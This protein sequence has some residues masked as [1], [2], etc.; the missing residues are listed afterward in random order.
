VSTPLA[1][2][3]VALRDAFP[4]LEELVRVDVADDGALGLTARG[5]GLTRWFVHDERGLVE[6]FPALDRKLPLSAWLAARRGWRVLSFR[7]G[8]RM[9]VLDSSEKHV[10]V[11]K[12]HKRGRAERAAAHQRLAEA[13]TRRGAFRVPRLVRVDL[14]HEALVFEHLSVG[15]CALDRGALGA[16]ARLGGELAAFQELTA[17]DGLETFGVREEL[18]VLERWATRAR[19]A[20]GALPT[21][22]EAAAEGLRLRAAELPPPR[23]GLAHRDL[24]DRQVHLAGNEVTLLDFDLLCRADVALDPANLCAH[25]EWRALQ[26]LHGAEPAGVRALA[27][28]FLDALG[29]A[30]EPG[31]GTRFAFY[32]A[33]TLLRLALVYRLRPRWSERTQQLVPLAEA[34]LRQPDSIVPFEDSP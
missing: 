32:R 23:L 17:G 28:A 14:E 5:G 20:L 21:G 12:G 18:E 26:G 1:A 10:F 6:A 9:V 19:L 22:W 2:A 25:L 16:Y 8:R 29:R 4:A 27:R 30:R 31:F 34:G 15:E 33:S 24:H 11:W 3:E 13:G 7:P